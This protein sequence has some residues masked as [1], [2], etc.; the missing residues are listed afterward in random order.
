MRKVILDLRGVRVKEEVHEQF[1]RQLAFP[2]YYGKNLDALYDCLGDIGEDTVLVVREKGVIVSD[3]GMP[4]NAADEAFY[5]RLNRVL[6]QAEK[7][8]PHLCVVILKGR[9]IPDDEMA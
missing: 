2:V 9:L 3:E 6:L 4:Q 8:N 1:A 7:K 5:H